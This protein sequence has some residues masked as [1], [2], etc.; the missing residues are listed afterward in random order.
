VWLKR[1]H[2]TRLAE[3]ELTVWIKV[4]WYADVAAPKTKSRG[5][6]LLVKPRAV[7]ARWAAEQRNRSREKNVMG[8]IAAG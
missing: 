4:T 7:S 2:G 5:K 3:A 6:S 8:G 1:V